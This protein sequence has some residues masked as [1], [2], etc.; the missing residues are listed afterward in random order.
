MYLLSFL[1]CKFHY[2]FELIALVWILSYC[3]VQG[4]FSEAS[5]P[6]LARFLWSLNLQAL[7]QSRGTLNFTTMLTRNRHRHQIWDRPYQSTFLYLLFGSS[8]CLNVSRSISTFISSHNL[9][10]YVNIPLVVLVH[11]KFIFMCFAAG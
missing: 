11:L 1:L 3:F 2:H 6:K 4:P 7:L 5:S 8:L 10:Q 9:F